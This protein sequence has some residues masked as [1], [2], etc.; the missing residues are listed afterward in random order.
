[1]N[2]KIE[3]IKETTEEL[4]KTNKAI[5]N[6]YAKLPHNENN[7]S[8]LNYYRAKVEAFTTILDLIKFVEK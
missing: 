1:M 6:Q 7:A 8:I 2:K 3:S 5:F 4:L